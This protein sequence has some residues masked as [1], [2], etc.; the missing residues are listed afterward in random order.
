[1][2]LNIGSVDRAVRIVGG[3]GLILL[4]AMGLIGAWGYI[5]M[6]P[7]V[8]G[9]VRICPAYILLG[10][11]PRLDQAQETD[12]SLT[13]GEHATQLLDAL[14]RRRDGR[15]LVKPVLGRSILEDVGANPRAGVMLGQGRS[16]LDYICTVSEVPLV[17]QLILLGKEDGWDGAW[18]TWRPFGS[19]LRAA[20]Q[21]TIWSDQHVNL[22]RAGLVAPTA[23]V[24]KLWQQIEPLAEQLLNAALLTA[25]REIDRYV[26]ECL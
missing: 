14:L 13:Q 25:Q 23:G 18:A 17:G 24:V 12:M 3:L 19:L 9:M 4:A 21:L 11:G 2:N 8:T 10:I 26:S 6:L 20:P 16:L 5:G 22:I 7:L 1:M 15:G